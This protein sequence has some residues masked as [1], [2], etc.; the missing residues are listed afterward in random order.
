MVYGASFGRGTRIMH[1]PIDNIFGGSKS[2]LTALSGV[3]PGGPGGP[4]LPTLTLGF[5]APKLSILG[6]YLI[7]PFFWPHFIWHI[8]SLIFCFFIIQIQNFSSLALLGI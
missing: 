2:H 5:E 1:L 3:D 7:F 8:I 6:L 4:R